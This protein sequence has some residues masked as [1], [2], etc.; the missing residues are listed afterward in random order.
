MKPISHFHIQRNSR[1]M[2]HERF[3][4]HVNHSG[5]PILSSILR[6]TVS[7]NSFVFG[8]ENEHLNPPGEPTWLALCHPLWFRNRGPKQLVAQHWPREWRNLAQ[9]CNGENF[10]KSDFYFM[11]IHPGDGGCN[12][13]QVP[14]SSA[15]RPRGPLLSPHPALH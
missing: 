1:Q 7:A 14:R 10:S 9:Q 2:M 13:L 6:S 3:F 15:T 8:V 5:G 4:N 11:L 12:Q